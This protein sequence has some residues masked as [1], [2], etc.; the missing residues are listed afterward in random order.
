MRFHD[1]AVLLGLMAM[2]PR[3]E[4]S[5]LSEFAWKSRVLVLV[6][7]AGDSE[8]LKRQRQIYE[9]ASRGMSERNVVL[10]EAVGESDRSRDIRSRLGIDG[11]S[12][13]VLLVG[14]DGHTAL[15]SPTP[16]TA[17]TLFQRIDAM[18]MRRDEMRRAQ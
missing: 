7:P 4:A 18:P 17:D 1:G 14:K 6:A 12:F 9:R 11:K 15:S 8:A 16:L 10:I 3:V 13:T 2:M 5:S